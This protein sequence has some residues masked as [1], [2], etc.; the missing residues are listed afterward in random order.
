VVPTDAFARALPTARDC[1]GRERHATDREDMGGVG[2]FGKDPETQC[3][4]YVSCFHPF[5]HQQ[6][7]KKSIGIAQCLVFLLLFSATCS[8]NGLR[9]T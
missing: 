8:E 5:H 6:Q 1:F 3:T 7:Q 2:S 4:L 9:F